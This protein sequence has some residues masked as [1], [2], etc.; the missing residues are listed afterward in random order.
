[1]ASN[2]AA[3]RHGVVRPVGTPEPPGPRAEQVSTMTITMVETPDGSTVD[4]KVQGPRDNG[5]AFKMLGLANAAIVK[6][7]LADAAAIQVVRDGG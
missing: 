6:R 7:A 4:L 1:M 5:Q 3:L 2:D